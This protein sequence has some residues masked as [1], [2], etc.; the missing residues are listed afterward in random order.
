MGL[1]LAAP[2]ATRPSLGQSE[3]G[4]PL[5]DDVFTLPQQQIVLQTIFKHFFVLCYISRRCPFLGQEAVMR[6]GLATRHF[7]AKSVCHASYVWRVRQ[8]SF[9]SYP[10]ITNTR[11]SKRAVYSGHSTGVRHHNDSAHRQQRWRLSAALS[12]S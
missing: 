8:Q 2:H 5:H 12:S 4:Q 7:P 6:L 10:E 1:W 3:A 11:L 9:S